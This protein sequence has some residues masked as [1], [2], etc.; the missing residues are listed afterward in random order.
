MLASLRKLAPLPGSTRI[1]CTHE[2]T[3]SNLKFARAVEPSN[4][5]LINY[6][7]RCQELRGRNL[8]SLPSTIEQERDINP[9]LRTRLPAVMHA[10]SN[11]DAATPPDDVALFAAVRK[12]KN[13][14][15]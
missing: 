8:P 5:K 12:W 4:L 1:C 14:F 13:E 2:Y 7:L 3:L 11:Y 15:K 10:A 6:Q 9:F